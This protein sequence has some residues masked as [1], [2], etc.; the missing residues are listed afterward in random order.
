MLKNK[1]DK[2]VTVIYVMYSNDPDSEH[3]DVTF[4]MCF[5]LIVQNY[6]SMILF[7]T[8]WG[9]VKRPKLYKQHFQLIVLYENCLITVHLKESNQ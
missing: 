8:Y 7:L 1:Q 4:V 6:L 2:F 5:F 3:K 9:L